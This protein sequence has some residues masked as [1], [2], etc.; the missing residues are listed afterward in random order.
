MARRPVLVLLLLPWLLFGH[1]VPRRVVGGAERVLSATSVVDASTNP[2][3]R[4]DDSRDLA[5]SIGAAPRGSKVVP[6]HPSLADAALAE[7]IAVPP[8]VSHSA[9][10]QPAS[11]RGLRPKRLAIPHNANAPPRAQS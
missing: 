6:R 2:A 3:F 10:Q 1:G 11:E 5:R 4:V 8:R 7:L 9:T